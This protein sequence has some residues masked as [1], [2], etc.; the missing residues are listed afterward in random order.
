MDGSVRQTKTTYVTGKVAICLA[1]ELDVVREFAKLE[2]L[3]RRERCL[4]LL[5]GGDADDVTQRQRHIYKLQGLRKPFGKGRQESAG[6]VVLTGVD[7]GSGAIVVELYHSGLFLPG[8]WYIRQL[9]DGE[10][11]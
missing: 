5:D 2:R 9:H 10:I 1:S 3:V 11:S 6:R 4:N 8:H 7:S